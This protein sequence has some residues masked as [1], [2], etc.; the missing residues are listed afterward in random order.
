MLFCGGTCGVKAQKPVA[1]SAIMDTSFVDYDVLFNELDALLDSLIKPRN[2]TLFD[3]SA[4]QHYFNYQS[5]SGTVEVKRKFVY[6]PSL[7]YLSRSGVGISG[8]ASVISE[9]HKVYPYQ[10]YL[11]GSYDYLRNKKLLTGIAF[12]RFFTKDSLPF[13][14]SPLKNELYA[15]INYRKLWFKPA[16][17]V[18][19]GWGS[20]KDYQ[21][22]SDYLSSLLPVWN[23]S[24][25][26]NN[27]ESINDFNLTASLRHDF[28]W[29]NVLSKK[30]YIRL[31]P[32]IVFTS[33]T[34]QFGFNQTSNSYTGIPKT[35][36]SLLYS[37]NKIMLEN[38]L[39]FQP[40]SLS[41]MMKTEYAKGKFFIQPQALLGYYFPA[42]DKL[43]TLFI[44]DAGVIL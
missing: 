12:T 32:H 35:N 22:Q 43:N 37:T 28:Y 27:R 31:T 36:M 21:K 25:R 38:H 40:L 39:N 41:V 7:I 42:K 23:G 17:A 34:Q 5:S 3:V 30:D 20:R 26:V 24:T 10:F 15:Y 13:Y 29:M 6:T 33:G 19:Y 4:S 14:T 44:I 1:D 18:T 2:I 8:A 16:I 9:E 11:T